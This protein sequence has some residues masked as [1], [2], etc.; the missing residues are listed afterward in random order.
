MLIWLE[1]LLCYAIIFITP[2]FLLHSFYVPE[3]LGVA[4]SRELNFMSVHV[5]LY[6][7]MLVEFVSKKVLCYYLLFYK[8]V[9]HC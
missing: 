9:S 8:R 7:C 3:D 4:Q 6:A 5:L 2:Y 1:F